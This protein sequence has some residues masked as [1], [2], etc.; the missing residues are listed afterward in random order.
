MSQPRSRLPQA[1]LTMVAFFFG[2]AAPAVVTAE[3]PP[4]VETVQPIVVSAA[5]HALTVADAPAATTVLSREQ[6]EMKAADDVLEALRGETGVTVFG[7]TIGGRK[8]LAL[9]GFDPKHT[10]FLVDG[11]RISASDGV[12]GHS[13]F[14]LEWMAMP[15]VERIEVVR[16]PLASLY[17]AEALGGVVQVFTRAPGRKFEAN[18]ALD[19]YTALSDRGG[20]GARAYG[21][22]SVPLNERVAASFS[23]A[24]ARS[25][26]VASA[27]DPRL[28]DLEG[29]DRLDGTARLRWDVASGHSLDL[30]QRSGREARWL[31]SI[32]KSGRRRLYQSDTDIDRSHSSLA[33]NADWT[34]LAP[35]FE[36][37]SV[38]RAYRSALEMTNARTNGVAPL[39]PSKL[40]DRV[41]DGQFSARPAAAHF[42]V[43]GVEAREERLIN[44]GLPG[45]A[46]SLQHRSI[47]AQ[48]EWTVNRSATLTAGLRYDAHQRYGSQWSPRLYG[49]WRVAPSWVIKGGYSYG[50]KP[51]TLK[52]VT[53]GYQEDE[54]PYT[55]FANPGVR[56]ERNNGMEI[57]AVWDTERIGVQGMLFDN[58]V[59][60]LIV[61][62]PIGVVAG[63]QSYV[64]DNIDQ[65]RLR[66]G[67]LTGS[68]RF[69]AQWRLSANYQYLDARDGFGNRIEKR[70][71]HT[72]GAALDWVDG[73]W[74]AN[75][76]IDSTAGQVLLTAIPTEAAKPA[77]SL[78][79]VGAS[80][81]RDLNRD[82]RIV[83]SVSNLGNVNPALRST[84]YTWGE[85]PRTVRLALH[86]RW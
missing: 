54:G 16:G 33:W 13:D 40:D 72:M 48:D 71:R 9:R 55:F 45:G 21:R 52:Q 50:Y 12:I 75:L 79:F 82:W 81:A 62:R 83:A 27:I 43:G 1:S 22:L 39:R 17:G 2:S 30:E 76:R 70:P 60:D 73:A 64:Y 29:R 20:D 44:A 56:A 68:L 49:V 31:T 42:V 65:A 19:G 66:G 35:T 80:L 58:R 78:S 32:E 6:I 14:Q 69:G 23:V 15:E 77:P 53:P 3:E 5:R 63:R 8:A 86:G 85:A 36:V 46:A 59:R 51:P 24:Q 10:L 67:E 74:R 37:T 25:Q 28:S 84:L 41:L 7:R 57:G 61:Q 34:A 11:K 47:Y 38:V 26:A 18:V 4:A